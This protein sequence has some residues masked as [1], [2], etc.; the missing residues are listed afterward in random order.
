MKNMKKI[1]S[2]V[3]IVLMA[4]MVFAETAPN[5]VEF[6]QYY[7]Q[8][9][10]LPAGSYRL[11][12]SIGGRTFTTTVRADGKYGYS[13]TFKVYGTNTAPTTFSIVNDQ[14][15]KTV[16]GSAAHQN[17]EVTLIN[18]Q[19]PAPAQ[20][21]ATVQTN[22]S[23]SVAQS[24]TSDTSSSSNHPRDTSLS[25]SSLPSQSCN[26]N[27]DCGLW[28]LCADTKQTRTCF[29]SDS[30]D[31]QLVEGKVLK[32]VPTLKPQEERSCVGELTGE[33]VGTTTSTTSICSAL[34]RRCR[35]TEVQQ[36]SADGNTWQTID[37]CEQGCDTTTTRCK[38]A[39]VVPSSQKP[40]TTLWY[41]IGGG[42]LIVIAVIL[43][44]LLLR[45]KSSGDY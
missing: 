34:A 40:E 37:S 39:S 33:E 19:Y 13:P 42:I 41:L 11:E 31:Q 14:G 30:C 18:M 29:R 44:V 20:S 12:A 26:Q 21:Q 15:I 38:A 3:L 17:R 5:L 23:G 25:P 35:G 36:C 16:L 4:A 6:Q 9:L 24:T 43:L 7:G 27:W 8:V 45:R 32:V 28:S 2:F 1:L 10:S 22:E